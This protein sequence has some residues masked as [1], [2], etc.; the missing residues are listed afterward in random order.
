VKNTLYPALAVT[1]AIL[2]ANPIAADDTVDDTAISYSYIEGAFVN[3]NLNLNGAAITD[4]DGVGNMDDD[5][6]GTLF[7]HTGNGGS[8]RLSAKLPF[9]SDK[10]GFHFVSDYTQTSHKP[11][12]DI[13]NAVGLQASGFVDASQ[14]ELRAA[15]GLHTMISDKVSLFAELGFVKNQVSLATASLT[16]EGAGTTEADLSAASSSRTALD[17]KFGLRAMVGSKVELMGYGRYHGNGEIIGGEDGA[18]DFSSKFKAGAGAY[19]HVSKRFA[20][21]ADYEFGKPG[22]VRLVGRLKF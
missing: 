18:L 13:V 4:R 11:G 19:Y 9:G 20:L 8:G 12:I 21:G 7:D 16:V 3:D 17:G 22:R 6:F 5:N 15:F 2:T 10:L 14:K 1:T